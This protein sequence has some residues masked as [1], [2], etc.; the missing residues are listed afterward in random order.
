MMERP[1]VL[2]DTMTFWQ[3]RSSRTLTVED[4]RQALENISGFFATLQRWADA[5]ESSSSDVGKEKG[6]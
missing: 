5:A 2:D 4:A 6:V 3:Q 1:A